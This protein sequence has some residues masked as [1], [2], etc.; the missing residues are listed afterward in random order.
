MAQ[1]FVNPKSTATAAAI[2]E[3]AQQHGLH[4][5]TL[6]LAWSK[7]HDYV[8]STIVGANSLEQLAPSLAA[9]GCT[10]SEEILD[11]VDA[12]SERFLYPMG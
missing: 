6:A 8:A 2:I 9:A 10:L 5:V 11:A 4:P 3:L 7:Q 1:R 12:I